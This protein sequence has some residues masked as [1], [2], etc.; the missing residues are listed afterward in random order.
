[1]PESDPSGFL[2]VVFAG[3]PPRLG[4]R[5]E[6]ARIGALRVLY[7]GYVANG[8]ARA[9]D[10]GA[11]S[12]A[13]DAAF[14]AAAYDRWGAQLPRYVLGEYAVAIYDTARQSLTLAHDELGLM[15]L[16]YAAGGGE[17]AFATHLGDLVEE[18]GVGELDEEYV[19]DYFARGEHLGARTPY[20]RIARLLPGESIVYRDGNVRGEST[21]TLAQPAPAGATSVAEEEARLRD[22]LDEAVTSALPADKRVLCEL[23]GGLD[24]STIY[25]FA[26][27]ASGTNVETLSYVYSRSHTADERRWI[28]IV[29]RDAPSAWHPLDVDGTPALSELPRERIGEPHVWVSHLALNRRY[30]ETVRATG[31]SAVL[32]GEGGDSVLCGDLQMPFFLADRL[33]RGELSSLVREGRPWCD[34]LQGK[35]SLRHVL[36]RF[37]VQGLLARMRGE[38]LEHR[39]SEIPWA[40]PAYARRVELFSRGTRPWLPPAAGAGNAYALQRVMRSANLVATNYHFR[41][42]LPPSRHPM[43]YRPLLEFM[44]GVDWSHKIAPKS[45]RLLQRGALRSIVPDETLQRRDKGGSSQPFFDGLDASPSWREALTA[46]PRI[47]ERGYARG[48]EWR[49]AVELARAGRTSDLS[50]FRGAAILEVWLQHLEAL[51]NGGDR[52]ISDAAAPIVGNS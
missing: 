30:I 26:R 2:G 9:D 45:D 39:T 43:L 22:L 29:L 51:R 34:G 12:T 41:R 28:D 40:D 17:I 49:R 35:R 44:L 46:R 18:I 6:P 13:G 37:A 23:S 24:S 7:R 3:A 15:P 31:A 33:A 25:N 11:E 48:A 8:S 1:M 52:K 16:F 38:A 27:R 5:P 19:A 10:G 42:D 32:T 36:M 4:S 14:F 47:V 20:A 21:W 50:A